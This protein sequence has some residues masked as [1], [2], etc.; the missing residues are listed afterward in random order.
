MPGVDAEMHRVL[1][2]LELNDVST[3][4]IKERSR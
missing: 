3:R 2:L 1:S 4:K